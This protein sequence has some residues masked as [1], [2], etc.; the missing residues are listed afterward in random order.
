MTDIDVKKLRM[1]HVSSSDNFHGGCCCS[2]R[3][4]DNFGRKMNLNF[5]QFKYKESIGNM[6]SAASEKELAKD[7][8]W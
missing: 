3:E 2:S 7:M 8:Y 4:G 1:T 5:E 6:K